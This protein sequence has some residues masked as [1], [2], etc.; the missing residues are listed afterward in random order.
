MGQ[1]IRRVLSSFEWRP[2]ISTLRHRSALAAYPLA[3]ASSSMRQLSGLAPDEVYLAD[4]VTRVAGGLL[5]HRFTLT[6][7]A[8]VCFLLHFLAGYPEWALPTVML[9]GART[10]LK[11]SPAIAWPTHP[12]SSLRQ[13]KTTLNSRWR[14]RH[15]TQRCV[16]SLTETTST[17][18]SDQSRSTVREQGA[19]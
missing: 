14:L 4:S 18:S 9:F 6:A 16:V 17:A 7:F 11:I 15:P 3:R 5:H 13:P 8:A 12:E 1:P 10:F 2:S 19:T